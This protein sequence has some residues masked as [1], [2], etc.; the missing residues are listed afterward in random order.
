MSTIFASVHT[1]PNS[2]VDVAAPAVS[3]KPLVQPAVLVIFGATGDLTARKLLPALFGLDNG[4]YLPAELVIIG[5]ARRTN[6]DEQ[7]REDVRKALTKFRP[8]SAAEPDIV[9]RFIARVFY[10]CADFGKREG[11]L[12][13]RQRIE[14]MEQAAS[15]AWQPA[16]LLG[17]RS[18]ILRP[19]Y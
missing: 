2:S 1:E 18:R 5:V 15:A 19:N 6:S 3:Q 17:N 4:G 9:E 11:M 16:L 10:H 12:G 8:D 14:G 13:L 7:F